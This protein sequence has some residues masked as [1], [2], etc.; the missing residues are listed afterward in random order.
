MREKERARHAAK[1]HGGDSNR[2]RCILTIWHV[3]ASSH[4]KKA[5]K[6]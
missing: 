6:K 5:L 1:G 2:E 3:V 4:T